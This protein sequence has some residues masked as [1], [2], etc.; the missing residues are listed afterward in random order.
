MAAFLY[1]AK[2]ESRTC[3]SLQLCEGSSKDEKNK[4]YT[5]SVGQR[6]MCL[7]YTNVV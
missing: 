2:A 6:E 5:T 7:D 3:K 1:R 4:F